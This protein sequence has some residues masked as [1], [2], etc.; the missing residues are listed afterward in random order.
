MADPHALQPLLDAFGTRAALVGPGGLLVATNRAW[1]QP[2]HPLSGPDAAVGDGYVRRLVGTAGPLLADAQWVATAIERVLDGEIGI[3]PHAFRFGSP[4]QWSRTTV[5]PVAGPTRQVAVLYEDVTAQVR[6]EQALKHS[7]ARLRTILTGAP[8]V[9]FSLDRE[10]VITV[11][12]GM[13]GA[14]TG[15]VTEDLVGS[16][17][18]EAYRHMPDLLEVIRE[19]LRGR[20]GV[21]TQAVGHLAFEIRCSPILRQERVVG[22]VGVATDV[23]E[24]LRAQRMKDEFVSIVSHEL[25]TP[26]TSIRGSL[27][28]LEGGVAGELP[29]KAQELVRI[30]RTNSDRLI[31]L[32]NDIL[33]LDKMEAGRLE[34]RREPIEIGALVDVVVA[35]MSGY[36]GAAGVAVT[37]EVRACE[38]IH[39]DRDRLAQVLVNLVSNAIK[40]S[41]EGERVEVRAFPAPS[42]VSGRVRV[43]VTDHG[44]GIARADVPKLFQKFHQLDASDTRRRGG[45]GLGLVIA[46][47]LVEA[48]HGH[49]GVDSEVGRGSTFYFEVPVHRAQPS[50]VLTPS[51]PSTPAVTIER[52]ALVDPM[53]RGTGEL[54]AE[55]ETHL[56]N[57]ART[58]DLDALADAQATARILGAALPADAPAELRQSTTELAHALDEAL[59]RG[60]ALDA[61]IFAGEN[62]DA[63]AESASERL[64]GMAARLRAR[65]DP[66]S[67]GSGA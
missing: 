41:P 7:Q 62:S 64:S 8:I 54:L 29:A 35:E 14:G 17:I 39:G 32:I 51:R 57:A 42:H 20:E 5:C 46:K 50:R 13:G 10:G 18:Y 48:H 28:L 59:R 21:V 9:L 47:R 19:A 31:R 22:V 43:S 36:A 34:L 40:F 56:R 38:P 45:S 55:L 63:A 15:F 24:R 61:E 33:D 67:G 37:V 3:P 65:L 44:P 52:Q 2:G 12:E 25:R 23:T 27:G 66:P 58:G 60:I 4:V 16:S 11:V 6:A 53:R 26:L 49:I 30:A 1:R